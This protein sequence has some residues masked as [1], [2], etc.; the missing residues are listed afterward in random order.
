MANRKVILTVGFMVSAVFAQPAIAQ[1][2]R[3]ARC[4]LN[5]SDGNVYVTGALTV[6]APGADDG[7]AGRAVAEEIGPDLVAHV[8]QRFGA[9]G[10]P[11]AVGC[12]VLPSIQV[13][14]AEIDKLPATI[15]GSEG[16]FV[17]TEWTVHTAALKAKSVPKSGSTGG[18]LI[19]TE[20]KPTATPV[21]RVAGTTVPKSQPRPS[22]A[23]RGSS[24]SKCH[25]EGKRYVCP[26]S[27]Q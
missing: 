3:G 6:N 19:I 21:P 4:W 26:A 23:G 18:S 1:D 11:K 8:E 20:K 17:R 15:N 16:R 2:T 14:Q 10:D 12:A 7:Q 13:A 22:A 27:K 9:K 5:S 25:L 24:K